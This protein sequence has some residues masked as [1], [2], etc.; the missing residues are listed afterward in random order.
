MVFQ[1]YILVG[2]GENKLATKWQIFGYVI[3]SKQ[4]FDPASTLANTEF[5]YVGSWAEFNLKFLD[6]RVYTH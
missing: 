4:W 6:I 3:Q 5:L 2:T 1:G